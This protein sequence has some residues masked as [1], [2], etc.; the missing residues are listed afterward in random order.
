MGLKPGEIKNQRAQLLAFVQNDPNRLINLGAS[1]INAL[2]SIAQ[3][4][5]D[6]LPIDVA[7]R[8]PR[9]WLKPY[10]CG[11]SNNELYVCPKP[12]FVIEHVLTHASTLNRCLSTDPNLIQT[13][14]FCKWI[15]NNPNN[16]AGNGKC[17]D[18][19][20]YNKQNKCEADVTCEWYSGF[21][22]PN[23]L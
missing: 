2:D 8:L 22:R 13:A 7:K 1:G 6:K 4:F 16:F 17:L 11:F 10:W 20:P 23:A 21:C 19:C 12:R 15:P 9:V 14:K 3:S 18:R 5:V